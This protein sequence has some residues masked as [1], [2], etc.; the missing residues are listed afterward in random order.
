[1]YWNGLSRKEQTTEIIY[2][3]GIFLM[4]MVIAGIGLWSYFK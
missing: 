2:L 3:S 1:M 4:L